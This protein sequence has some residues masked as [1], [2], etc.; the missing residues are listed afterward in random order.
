MPCAP[1]VFASAIIQLLDN[2]EEVAETGKGVREC[3]VA[4]R[5]YEILARQVEN[6]YLEPIA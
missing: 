4:N 5:S 2:P 3:V 6:R 1:E